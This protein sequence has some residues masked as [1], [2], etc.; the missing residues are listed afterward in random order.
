MIVSL[1]VYLTSHSKK[2]GCAC[3]DLFL[4]DFE[5]CSGA[6]QIEVIPCSKLTMLSSCILHLLIQFILLIRLL[7]SLRNLKLSEYIIME[8]NQV[9][10]LTF[11]S[12]QPIYNSSPNISVTQ[13]SSHLGPSL[14][15]RSWETALWLDP[16]SCCS[17]H[18][19]SSA[20]PVILLLGHLYVRCHPV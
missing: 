2:A 12:C 17:C 5:L 3:A 13:A 6:G 11:P 10:P 18:A 15:L 8:A 20:E 1:F 9:L 19:D 14:Q 4:L 7:Q 16:T